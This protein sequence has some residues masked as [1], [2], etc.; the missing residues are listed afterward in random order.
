MGAAQGHHEAPSEFWMVFNADC[1]TLSNQRYPRLPHRERRLMSQCSKIL[2]HMQAHGSITPL[3]AFNLYKSLACHSRIAELRE[4]G[5]DIATEMVET[6]SGNVVGRYR[7]RKAAAQSSTA[8]DLATVLSK[9]SIEPGETASAAPARQQDHP[10]YEQL[11]TTYGR[12]KDGKE[13]S[14]QYVA[15]GW[16]AGCAPWER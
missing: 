3:E 11:V 9:E 12:D 10:D 6:P 5:H 2:A 7:L 1:K 8:N 4:R 16:A 14:F 15:C 13:Y